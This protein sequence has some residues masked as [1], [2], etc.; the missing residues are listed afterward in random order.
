MTGVH[1]FTHLV[2]N[3]MLKLENIRPTLQRKYLKHFMD[4]L[5]SVN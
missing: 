3:F 5:Q 4:W 2:L 1:I